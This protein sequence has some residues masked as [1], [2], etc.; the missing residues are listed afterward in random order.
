MAP[1]VAWSTFPRPIDIFGH[2]IRRKISPNHAMLKM[3]HERLNRSV[4]YQH[5]AWNIPMT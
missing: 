2:G 4:V 1:I 5:I 3:W